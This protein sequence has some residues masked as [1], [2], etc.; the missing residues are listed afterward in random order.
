MKPIFCVLIAILA[1]AACKA[2]QTDSERSH[3]VASSSLSTSVHP[4]DSTSSP[5]SASAAVVSPEETDVLSREPPDSNAYSWTFPN[6]D[7]G[8]ERFT[9]QHVRHPS[10]LMVIWFD[11]ATRATEDTPART[12]HVDSVVV[13]G[14]QHGEYLTF[15]CNADG[16]HDT[17]K[18]QIVGILRDT[19]NYLRP[20][21]AWVL[22][23]VSYRIR[24]IPTDRVLCS[25]ADLFAEGEDD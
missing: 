22:D 25:A 11:T 7:N 13:S 16:R 2:E 12:T 17:R 4:S 8:N 5:R 9:G 19:T 3:E 14:L 21:M 24:A 6:M 1:C 23:T 10:G 18:S 20:R 15:Y